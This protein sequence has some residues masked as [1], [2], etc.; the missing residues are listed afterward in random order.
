VRVQ[1]L[2]LAERCPR[3]GAV[4]R[5]LPPRFAVACRIANF[6]GAP[7]DSIRGENETLVAVAEF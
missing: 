3:S 2:S 6:R 7:L 1:L 4:R 5:V